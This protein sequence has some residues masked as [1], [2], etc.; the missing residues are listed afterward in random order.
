MKLSY[1]LVCVFRLKIP[2]IYAAESV[3]DSTANAIVTGVPESGRRGECSS[4]S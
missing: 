2:Q 3:A 1:T 4:L